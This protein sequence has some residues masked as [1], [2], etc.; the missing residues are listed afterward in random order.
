LKAGGLALEQQDL[1]LQQEQEQ[2][3]RQQPS[4]LPKESLVENVGG[5]SVVF[6]PSSSSQGPL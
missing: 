1:L 4:K 3:L 6:D 2:K 5:E